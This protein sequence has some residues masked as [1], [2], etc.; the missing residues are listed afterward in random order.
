MRSASGELAKNAG[1]KKRRKRREGGRWGKKRI[2][3]SVV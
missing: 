1:K 2:R 3:T